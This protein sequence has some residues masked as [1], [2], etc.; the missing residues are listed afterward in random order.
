[1]AGPAPKRLKRP[2]TGRL[3][4]PPEEVAATIAGAA[5]ATKAVSS[6]LTFLTSEK[7]ASPKTIENYARDLLR[8]FGFLFDHLEGDATLE[9]LGNLSVSDLRAFLARRRREGLSAKSIARTLSS[10]RGFYG[11]LEREG[12][13]TNH[14]LKRLKTP[15]IP[16]SIPKPVSETNALNLLEDAKTISS[17]PWVAAR[18]TSIITLLYACG[19]R[20]AEALSLNQ[21]DAPLGETLRIIGKG[22]KERIVPVLPAARDAVDQYR[23]LCPHPLDGNDPLFVGVRGKRLNPREIQKLMATLR[24]RLG[25]PGTATP[26]ALRHSFA[27]HLLSAGGDLRSIQ[28]LL[29]HASLSSTQVY[30]E[31][32]ADRLREVYDKAHPA[33][34]GSKAT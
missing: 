33:Q 27:T 29:G 23:T 1:M 16:H 5:S 21:D 22:N 18:D 15:K 11:H 20:I 12:L 32:D 34:K 13:A 8:F 2:I 10:L 7:R 25:L 24:T 6:Y 19:L 3:N 30:T 9:D 28:E 26:H 14:A 17:E 31:I 4:G